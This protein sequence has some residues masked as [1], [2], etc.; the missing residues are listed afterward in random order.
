MTSQEWRDDA[1][2][3]DYDPE[4]WHPVSDTTAAPAIRI[5]TTV[6]PVREECLDFALNEG[7]QYGVWGGLTEKERR[8]LRAPQKLRK[9]TTGVS[10]PV[11]HHTEIMTR[12]AA[13]DPIP[14]IA[15]AVRCHPEAVKS[16]IKRQRALERAA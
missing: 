12:H 15:I 7:E 2:C 5:C 14:D 1:A 11:D 16:Y 6:C 13:G 8:Q 10:R 4:L 9:P 3:R